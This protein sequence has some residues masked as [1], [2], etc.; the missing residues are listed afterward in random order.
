MRKSFIILICAVF[1][2]ATGCNL[3]KQGTPD[4]YS[5]TDI[6]TNKSEEIEK[7]QDNVE[8]A[9][10]G[11]FH[12]ANLLN[13]NFVEFQSAITEAVGTEN[14]SASFM[15][16]TYPIDIFFSPTGEVTQ[17]RVCL[18]T[19]DSEIGGDYVMSEY[20]GNGIPGTASFNF[21]CTKPDYHFAKEF[22]DFDFSGFKMLTSW[23]GSTDL[24]TILDRYVSDVPYGYR[25]VTGLIPAEII[26]SQQ[27]SYV[28]LDLS[29]GTPA[30]IKLSS[31]SRIPDRY[32]LEY[33]LSSN[34]FAILPY[35]P[36]SEMPG[37]SVPMDRLIEFD[38]PIDFA[39][40]DEGEYCINN[41]LLLFP[42][43]VN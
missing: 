3:A 32:Y 40:P 41:I 12:N 10:P 34:Y 18:W 8:Q 14:I 27:I 29:S 23:I 1:V 36:M 39:A 20:Q 2:T 7:Y 11:Q 38:G 42:N 9:Q 5:A 15:Y 37:Y 25:F 6:S 19:L 16:E 33:D 4:Q 35:Y 17:C 13:L 30:E 21:V 26:D 24:Q 22:F 28:A 31:L 43:G